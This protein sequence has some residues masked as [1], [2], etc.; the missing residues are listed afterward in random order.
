MHK[1]KLVDGLELDEAH[2]EALRPGEY[3]Q[4]EDGNRRKLPRFFYEVE[5]WKTAKETQLAPHFSLYEFIATDLHEADVLREFPR[6]IPCALPLLASH[7]S[8]FREEV[9]TFV[10]IAANGGYRSPSHDNAR[11]ASR[12]HWGTAVN[13]YRIGDDYL[14]DQETIEHYGSVAQDVLPFTWVRPYGHTVGY[15]DDHL[16]LDLGYMTVIPNEAAGDQEEVGDE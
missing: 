3:L 14:D 16:H 15:A 7:L 11:C 13:I 5:S 9:G 12:H 8:S 10:H 6:Y 2:R 4:D 1:L